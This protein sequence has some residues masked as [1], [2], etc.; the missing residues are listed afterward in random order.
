[1]ILNLK[2]NLSMAKNK[3]NLNL[4]LKNIKEHLQNKIEQ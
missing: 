1:M 4:N 3:I 2:N